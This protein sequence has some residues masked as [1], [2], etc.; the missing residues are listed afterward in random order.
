MVETETTR[1]IQN[2]HSYN[3][4]LITNRARRLMMKQLL[5][6]TVT[7]LFWRGGGV[8]TVKI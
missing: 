5:C 2:T 7:E 6:F 1:Y 8:G 4:I 3:V